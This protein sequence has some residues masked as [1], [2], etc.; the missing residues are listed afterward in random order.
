[1]RP[2]SA[3]ITQTETEGSETDKIT[4]LTI[5]SIVYSEDNP[6]A[7]IGSRIVHEGEKV[8]GAT[9]VKINKDSVEFEAGG[10]KWKQNI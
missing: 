5:K 9:V 7:V 2:G 4:R 1:M 3:T 6:S 8:L 10:K